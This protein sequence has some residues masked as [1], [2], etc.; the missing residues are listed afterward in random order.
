MGNELNRTI[1]ISVLG[2]SATYIVQLI[3]LMIYARLFTPEVFGVIASISVFLVFFQLIS[4]IGIG[5]ALVNE[6]KISNEERNGIFSLTFIVGIVIGIIFYYFSNYLDTY[7]DSEVYSDIA[8]ILA[9]AI[10]FNC[11]NIVPNTAFVKDLKFLVLAKFDMLAQIMSL[12]VT[13]I[14]YQYAEP[15]VTLASKTATYSFFKFIMTWY[16][17]DNTNLG[18]ANFG[19]EFGYFNKIKSF[20]LYQFGFSFINYFSR[21][22]DDI[23]V[24]K[25][26][27][28]VQLGIYNQAYQLMRYPLQL[29]T[30]AMSS[31]I[32]AVLSKREYDIEYIISE[33]NSLSRKLLVLSIPISL[34][35]MFNANLIVELILG[36]K[37]LQV[38]PLLEI[39][40]LSIPIQMVIATSGAFY[41]SINRPD[42]LFKGGAVGA[43][44]FISCISTSILYND[45]FITAI[46]IVIAFLINSVVIYYVLFKFGFKSDVKP[47]LNI[48]INTVLKMS[49]FIVLFVVLNIFISYQLDLFINILISTLILIL[50]LLINYKFI[51]NVFNIKSGFK[52][53]S[54]HH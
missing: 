34:Y 54:N 37:W 39:L 26:I 6:M 23:L 46:S 24:A 31:A 18:R 45:I 16:E 28:V 10:P 5:P 1:I 43:F 41:Q 40:S 17:S 53:N 25:Y 33:H 32:Q 21:N 11:L 2:K 36:E 52:Y 29:T 8:L 47:F 22:L 42:L 20:S 48:L 3:S 12:V 51:L 14:V 19:S 49:P 13:L 35:F 44:I 4:D 9:L 15:I 7:Y 50:S 38:V 30:F 27:G